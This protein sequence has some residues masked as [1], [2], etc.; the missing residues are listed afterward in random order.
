[1]SSL[2][3]N[4]LRSFLTLLGIV[5][6]V[7]AVVF[8]MAMTH[9]LKDYFSDQFS[10]LGANTF[11][12][13]KWPHMRMGHRSWNKWANRPNINVADADA[14]RERSLAA[15]FVS[16]EVWTGGLVVRSR[17]ETTPANVN[18]VGGSFEYAD[19]NGYQI[20]WGR[21]LNAYDVL[22][23]RTVVVLGSDLAGTL[24]PH[25]S[26]LGQAVVFASREFTVV[27]VFASKGGFFGFGSQ[28]NFA[29]IPLTSFFGVFGL[30][31]SVNITVQ[32][33]NQEKFESARDQAIQIMRQQRR[34]RADQ[35]NDFEVFSNESTMEKVGS[36]TDSVAAFAMAIAFISLLV[37]G[38]GIMNIM[39]VSVT[40][41]T[42]EIGVRRALGA[43]RRNILWQ[44]TM[45]AVALSALGGL[46]GLGLGFW[47]AHVVR[48]VFGLPAAV[49]VWAVVVSLLMSSFTG[50]AFGIYPAWQASRLNPIEALRYE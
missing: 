48:E 27:G 24:F 37:G 32:A 49:P 10:G 35:E 20:A 19:N 16:P 34:I 7:A 18:V 4:K 50:L 6:G 21:N 25:T 46:L 12:I 3:A 29:H 42:R 5:I 15:G 11:Q 23:Q 2:T 41:R 8:M 44:F 28:D 36:V 31:R 13:Q 33:K 1:M 39:L 40:E 9:G 45:E 47:G 26:P 30:K 22:F 17:F 14:I 38:I 43:K